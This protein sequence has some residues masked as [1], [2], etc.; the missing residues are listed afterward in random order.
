M[1]IWV[2]EQTAPWI[3]PPPNTVN[4]ADIKKIVVRASSEENA[5]LLAGTHRINAQLRPHGEPTAERWSPFDMQA[6]STCSEVSP[7]G[8]EDVI[9]VET[10]A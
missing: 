5:R 2:L 4:N 9:A 7:D 6:H 3:E 10:G 8:P 1:P